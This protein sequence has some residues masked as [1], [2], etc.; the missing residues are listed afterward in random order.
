MP[1]RTILTLYHLDEMSYR[2]IGKIMNMP[3][4]TVK[5]YLHRARKL[6]RERLLAKYQPEEL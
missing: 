5:S 2:K 1:F 6:L 4:G 3:E